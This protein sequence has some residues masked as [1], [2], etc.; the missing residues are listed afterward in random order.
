MLDVLLGRMLEKVD[1]L[2]VGLRLYLTVVYENH[3]SNGFRI[4]A[5]CDS[6]KLI[7]AYNTMV[8]MLQLSLPKNFLL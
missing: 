6:T 2:G 3:R 5:T 1:E 8:Y 4:G 7:V